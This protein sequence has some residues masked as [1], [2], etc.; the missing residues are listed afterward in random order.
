M[1]QLDNFLKESLEKQR[2]E[3]L[4]REVNN[5]VIQESEISFC[6]NDYL[7]LAKLSLEGYLTRENLEQNTSSTSENLKSLTLSSLVGSSGSRLT[8]G[9][10]AIHIELERFIA[11]WKGTEAALVFNCGYMANLGLLSSLLSPRDVV[12]C[13]KLNHSSLNDGVRISKCKKYIYQ[14]NDMEH[15]E[16]LLRST[17][18]RSEKALIITDTVFGMD[19][20]LAK[21]A[22][23]TEL[24]KKYNC[25]VYVDEAHGTGVFGKQGSGYIE[26]LSEKKLIDKKDIAIQMGTLSKAIGLEGGYIAGSQDLIDFVKNKCRTFIY[27]TAFSPLI[28]KLALENLKLASFDSSLRN[29]LWENIAYF[30]EKLGAIDG[31]R[32][33]NA[34][35]PIFLLFPYEEGEGKLSK[36]S[37]DKTLE[38]SAKLK[39]QGLIA[40]AIR[41]PTSE[42]PRIRITL[43]AAHSKEDLDLLIEALSSQICYI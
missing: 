21:I 19:G 6:G 9:S 28:A 14:H 29:K 18:E 1:K 31:L 3:G 37:I 26:E 30:R 41:P 38:L 4:F 8:S 12:Y 33:S 32:W 43:S 36:T 2:E 20:D 42:T 25:S 39:E 16:D 40:V 10:H 24:S 27:T 5:K 35:T 23:I 22:E 13:D 7:G 34:E 15:L 11:E 17:R